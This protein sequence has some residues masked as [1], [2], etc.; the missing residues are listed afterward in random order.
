MN[1]T[2]TFLDVTV[3]IKR[4]RGLHKFET[5]V[6]TSPETIAKVLKDYSFSKLLSIKPKEY[7]VCYVH[8]RFDDETLM[9]K[10]TTQGD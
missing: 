8:N 1:A 2:L 6:T 3:T 4:F 10:V 5:L 9:M 7:K